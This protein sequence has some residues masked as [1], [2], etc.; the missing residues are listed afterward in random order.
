MSTGS[1]R[2]TAC[3]IDTPPNRRNRS[4]QD[5]LN[6]FALVLWEIG[7]SE[8]D[9]EGPAAEQLVDGAVGDLLEADPE[10]SGMFDVYRLA[11][12]LDD[13]RVQLAADAEHERHH[14][15]DDKPN[16]DLQ[17]AEETSP[18]DPLQDDIFRAKSDLEDALAG[19]GD[20]DGEAPDDGCGAS[21]QHEHEAVDVPLDED[22]A[23]EGGEQ[24]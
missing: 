6:G 21:V 11:G 14:S 23:A 16:G 18:I 12:D 19:A 5:D 8:I 24:A 2:S 13:P 3:R 7:A 9:A 20:G 15:A 4:P 10:A 22:P 17:T 1:K